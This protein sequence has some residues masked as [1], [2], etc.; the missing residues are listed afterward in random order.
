MTTTCIPTDL[1]RLLKAAQVS[2]PGLLVVP[3]FNRYPAIDV[4]MLNIE[5]K[6]QGA[7]HMKEMHEKKVVL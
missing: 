6:T 7:Q 4:F 5:G 1:E 3:L 2:L